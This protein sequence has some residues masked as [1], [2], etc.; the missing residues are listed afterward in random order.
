MRARAKG[1]M[2]PNNRGEEDEEKPVVTKIGSVTGKGAIK[3]KN[4]WV[5]WSVSMWSRRS[6]Q[7][8]GMERGGIWG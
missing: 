8:C 6:G 4:N 5:C 2:Y 1:R 7:A 3:K